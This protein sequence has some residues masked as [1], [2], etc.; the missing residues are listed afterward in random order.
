MNDIHTYIS[1]MASSSRSLRNSDIAGSLSKVIFLYHYRG[2]VSYV[3]VW[4]MEG[5]NI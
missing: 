2:K 1:N 4:Y 5:L 3:C